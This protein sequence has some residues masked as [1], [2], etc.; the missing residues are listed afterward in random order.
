[1]ESLA[2]PYEIFGGQNNARTS[3]SPS[4]SVFPCYYPIRLGFVDNL[5]NFCSSVLSLSAGGCNKVYKYQ[6]GKNDFGNILC[7][8]ICRKLDFS[9]LLN[10]PLNTLDG[11]EKE[12]KKIGTAVKYFTVLLPVELWIPLHW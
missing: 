6:L 4:I 5:S 12:M 2:S 11:Q 3:L 7:M 10:E 8:R 9:V 1:L